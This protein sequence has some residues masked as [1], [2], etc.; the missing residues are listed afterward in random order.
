MHDRSDTTR[1]NYNLHLLDFEDCLDTETEIPALEP[2]DII[3]ERLIAFTSCKRRSDE[4]AGIHFFLDDCRFEWC[5]SDPMRYVPMLRRFA[6][7]F[8]PDFSV[9]VDMAMPQQLY[10]VYRGRTVGRIWQKAGLNVVPRG[11]SDSQKKLNEI[12]AK[13]HGRKWGRGVEI[14]SS[15]Y[16]RGGKKRK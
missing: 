16:S 7:V 3:P 15:K 9:Y 2:C 13:R 14:G 10:N 6:C 4:R 5:W 8:T 1:R 11:A 12:K